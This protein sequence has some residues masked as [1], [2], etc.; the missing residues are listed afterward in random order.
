VSRRNA[1]RISFPLALIS[2]VLAGC[3]TTPAPDYRGKWRPLNTYSEAPIELPLAN[4]YI[5]QASPMDGTLKTMLSRWAKDSGMQL[6]Y[7]FGSDFTLFGPVAQIDTTDIRDAAAQ[8]SSAY[9][10]HGVSI[11]VVSKTIT[12]APVSA[13]PT[14][15]EPA[16]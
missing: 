5:F 1:I 4:A 14:A 12:V 16:Q 8:L 11:Y 15:A 13:A 2:I 7:R 9:A 6:D 3:G 10:S